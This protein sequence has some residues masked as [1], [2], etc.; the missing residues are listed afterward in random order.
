MGSGQVMVGKMQGHALTLSVALPE[1]A[2]SAV[3]S[4]LVAVTVKDADPTGVEHAVVIVSVV[5][6]VLSVGEN[7]TAG[8][9]DAD[10]PAGKELTL[11]LALN[12]PEEPGPEPRLT[13]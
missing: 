1:V 10:A 3:L 6:F 4:V 9:N 2:L 13:V 8:E 11:M 7:D 5:V 12:A